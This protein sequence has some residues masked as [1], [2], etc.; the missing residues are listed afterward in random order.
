MEQSESRLAR[1]SALTYVTISLGVATAFF[2]AATLKGGYTE[3]ARFGGALWVLV[4]G[5]IVTMPLV[6]SWYKNR[7]KAAGGE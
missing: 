2:V 4:L 7:Q 3:V 5:L 6:T 1:Q